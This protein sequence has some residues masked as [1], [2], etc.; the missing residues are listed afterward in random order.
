MQSM[1]QGPAAQGSQLLCLRARAACPSCL[2]RHYREG[3]P[4]LDP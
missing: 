4:L 1:V 3:L 2:S